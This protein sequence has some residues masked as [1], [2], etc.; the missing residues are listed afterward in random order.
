MFKKILVSALA[1]GALAAMVG[2]GSYA[3]FTDTGSAS[4]TVTAATIDIVLDNSNSQATIAFSPQNLLPNENSSDTVNV[5]NVGNR[6]VHLTWATPVVTSSNEGQCAAANL[7]VAVAV[8]DNNGDD[9][10]IDEHIANGDDEDI[11]VTATLDNGAPNSCQGI[12]FTVT[13]N[14]T[15]TGVADNA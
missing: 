1:L 4:G 11:T 7:S 9:H 15:A 5:A 8:S 3:A 12:Q 10:G 14:F 2:A 6:D 13:V